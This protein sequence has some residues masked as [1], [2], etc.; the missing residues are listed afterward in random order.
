M[1]IRIDSD[2][3][4]QSI[5]VLNDDGA[6]LAYHRSATDPLDRIAR[7]VVEVLH[8]TACEAERLLVKAGVLESED[9]IG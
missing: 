3:L 8:D 9:V 6:T 4:G 7:A 5:E 1:K 2:A